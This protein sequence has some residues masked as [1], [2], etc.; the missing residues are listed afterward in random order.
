MPPGDDRVLEPCERGTNLGRR[1]RIVVAVD[2]E[3]R[4]GDPV[5]LAAEVPIADR[6]GAG[7][8]ALAGDAAQVVEDRLC[9]RVVAE[10]RAEPALAR[11]L[12]ERRG[13]VAPDE[14]GALVVL[15]SVAD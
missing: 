8:V 3:S 9:P 14:R 2:D 7:G 5:L 10:G 15:V 1:H 4:H 11:A 12:D 6:L 13:P